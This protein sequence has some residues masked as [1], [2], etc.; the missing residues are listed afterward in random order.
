MRRNTNR[1]FIFFFNDFVLFLKDCYF[2]YIKENFN[3]WEKHLDENRVYRHLWE[4][5]GKENNQVLNSQG[6]LPGRS[7]FQEEQGDR[8]REAGGESS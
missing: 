4:P 8:A 1:P 2:I 7:T 3:Q 6:V 5:R